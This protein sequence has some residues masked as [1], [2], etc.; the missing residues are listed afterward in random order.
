MKL[1]QKTTRVEFWLIFINFARDLGVKRVINRLETAA[2]PT[3]FSNF[4]DYLTEYSI[5][6]VGPL[7]ETY[8]NKRAK[9]IDIFFISFRNV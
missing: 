4:S 9:K 2:K 7:L 5:Q 6:I 8:G 3:K 1:L